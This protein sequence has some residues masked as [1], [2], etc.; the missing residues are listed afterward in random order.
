MVGLGRPLCLNWS[1]FTGPLHAREKLTPP[2]PERCRLRLCLDLAYANLGL[3]FPRITA[4]EGDGLRPHC[5]ND[6]WGYLRLMCINAPRLRL[7]ST[8]SLVVG[9]QAFSAKTNAN[10]HQSATFTPDRFSLF[11]HSLLRISLVAHQA[12]NQPYSSLNSLH[13]TSYQ[14]CN[15]SSSPCLLVKG[16]NVGILQDRQSPVLSCSLQLDPPPRSPRGVRRFFLT[17]ESLLQPRNNK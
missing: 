15:P 9:Y 16:L 7:P 8:K 3:L 1:G 2:A 4:C 11:C 13:L 5:T 6:N 17:R 10:R 14:S 12:N